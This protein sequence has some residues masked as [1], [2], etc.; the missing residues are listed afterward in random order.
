MIDAQFGRVLDGDDPVGRLSGR[1]QGGQ[2]RGLAGAGTAADQQAEPGLDDRGQQ[3]RQL[4]AQ[5]TER[6]QVGQ[7]EPAPAEHPQRQGRMGDQ[8]RQD[9]MQPDP[10]GQRRV[11]VGRGVVQSPA[12]LGGQPDRQPPD[13][14]VGVEAHRAAFQAG[15][16]IHPD[17][18]GGIDQHVGDA[19]LG[20]Q[21][22]QRPGTDQLC[23]QPAGQLGQRGGVEQQPGFP[24]G[25][26]G[27][28]RSR[29]NRRRCRPVAAGPGRP[30]CRSR[31]VRPAT[32]RPDG[33]RRPPATR[34]SPG[35][36]YA[37]GH[38]PVRSPPGRVPAGSCGSRPK[39]GRH[40]SSPIR[41]G[42][43]DRADLAPEPRVRC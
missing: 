37:V 7:A 30:G 20:Q 38:L 32:A 21:R 24:S 5:R 42:D 4:R 43:S 25:G 34:P 18:V 9:R 1:Q 33:R 3:R 2:Q 8:R 36:G 23:P 19:G 27:Q 6:Q 35:V 13:L 31:R 17:L 39:T 15:T 29:P 16:A 10:V 22:L 14:G 11:D 28:L 26:V 12:G 41:P 40:S